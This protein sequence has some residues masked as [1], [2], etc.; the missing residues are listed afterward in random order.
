MTLAWV[1]LAKFD[2]RFHLKPVIVGV[3]DGSKLVAIG[4]VKSG[5][6]KDLYVLEAIPQGL[7]Y[8]NI[9]IIHDIVWFIAFLHTYFD[10]Q[11]CMHVK[12]CH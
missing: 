7:F 11:A 9:I 10:L 6:N 3:P 4:M 1:E 8:Y 12:I 2:C 5:S